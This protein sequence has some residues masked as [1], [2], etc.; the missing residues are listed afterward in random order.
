MTRAVLTAFLASAL[1]AGC[2][3]RFDR[4]HGDDA[5]PDG[6]DGGLVTEPPP[7]DAPASPAPPRITPCPDGW[8]EAADPGLPDI[9]VCDPW[10][11]T[12]PQDCAV[13]EAHFP[14]EADCRRVGTPCPAGDW[15]DDLPAAG[16]VLFVLAGAGGGGDGSRAAPFSTL[17]EAI[18][19]APSGA[20]VALSK[21]T[22]DEVTSVTR[23]ITVWGACTQETIVAS[24]IPHATAATVTLR[25]GAT[26]RN[27]RVSGARRGV[28]VA[29]NDDAATLDSVVVH[30]AAGFG[31]FVYGAGSLVGRDLVIRATAG[32]A[33]GAF[34]YGLSVQEGGRVEI[35]RGALVGNRG[36]GMNLLGAATQVV[37]RDVAIGGT[38]PRENDDRFGYGVQLS[39]GAAA[40]LERAAIFAN[41]GSGVILFDAGTTFVARDATIRD[42]QALENDGLRG[43]GLELDGGV[44]AELERTTIAGN[45]DLGL[46]AFGAGAELVATDVVV[47][48]TRAQLADDTNGYALNLNEGARVTLTRAVFARNTATGILAAGV[49]TSL[50]ATDLDVSDTEPRLNDSSSGTGLQARGG[51]SIELVRTA[52]RRNHTAGVA[53]N[54]P[55]TTLVSTDLTVE[56][57][58]SRSSDGWGG[59]SLLLITGAS[60]GLSRALFARGRS[61][62]AFVEGSGTTLTASD[63]QIIDTGSR[64]SD[65][66]RGDGLQITAGATADLT[67]VR[68]VRARAHG[69]AAFDPSTRVT[70]RD[71]VVEETLREECCEETAYG[72]GIVAFAGTSI[73]ATGLRSSGNAICGVSVAGGEVDLHDGEVSGNPIGANVST[74]AFDLTRIQDRVVYRDN[75]RN[76][77]SSALP[78]PA[79]VEPVEP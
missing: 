8:R 25:A 74:E 19:A 28:N 63:L 17:A 45:R 20:V 73:E 52:L 47:T 54:E 56:D 60:A 23:P 31:V 12:G 24:S 70:A 34:G 78:A 1:G 50:V 57:T 15:A 65:G 61:V 71:L 40:T 42:T 9:S 48:D 49:G 46:G 26:L 6:G 53:V 21:G 67:R 37:A 62:G 5:G 2:G 51:A 33:I 58:Q 13:D 38:L 59:Y 79:P 43:V 29:G 30:G 77:D 18:A 14:G 35:D 76:L 68:I 75:D 22:F 72:T 36:I 69:V 4:G 44:H 27:L 16:T 7:L 66:T 11:A 32:D 55:G 3:D 10:P 41:R 39:D 64:T